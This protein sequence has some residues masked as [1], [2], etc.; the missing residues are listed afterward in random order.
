[1]PQVSVQIAGRTYELACGEG[2]EARVHELAT[3][4]DGKLKELAQSEDLARYVL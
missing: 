2:E 4:V 3:Y 1:M